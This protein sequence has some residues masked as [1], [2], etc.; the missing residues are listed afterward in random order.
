M[1][2]TKETKKN[3]TGVGIYKNTGG[4]GQ[5]KRYSI[6]DK[7]NYIGEYV[8]GNEHGIGMYES[9]I[10]NNTPHHRYA[11]QFND[12]KAEGIGI[13]S[14]KGSEEIYCGEYK[15]NER[16]GVGYWK[17]SSGAIFVGEH[18]D[19]I[20]NG[21]GMLITW[22]GFKFI[23]YVKDWIP[24]NGKWYDQEDNE[25]DITEL[26]YHQ[27]GIKYEGEY[28]NGLPTGQGTETF[29]D[30]KKYVGE[31]K[32][33]EKNGQGTDSF[34]DGSKYVGE[35]KGDKRHG[36]GTYTAHDGGT[37]VGGWQD[38]KMHGQGTHTD[39]AGSKCVGK[40]DNGDLTQVLLNI[41]GSP[42]PFSTVRV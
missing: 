22:E 30:G 41:S 39:I 24:V 5:F 36:Q 38:D 14:Y 23:G 26:G 29:P 4:G 1:I 35:F 37:Y 16:N 42:K 13:K 18:K 7:R 32:D 15:N 3:Y 21:S 6:Y 2:L 27:N 40:F 11:G 20:P 12:N 31:Y 9:R 25:I 19:H 28:K 33:G 34:P 17:L 8:D 10:I